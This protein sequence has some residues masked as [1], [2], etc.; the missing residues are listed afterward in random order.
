MKGKKLSHKERIAKIEDDKTVRRKIFKELCDHVSK[1]Y[2][3]ESFSG[4]SV[5]SIRKYLK[6]FSEEFVQEELDNAFRN[7]REMWETIGYRQANGQCLGNSRT[8]FY[9]MANRY[10]WRD[11]VEVEAEHKGQVSVN[12]VSYA[13]SKQARSNSDK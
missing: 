13:T 10:G 4:L 1:G 5:E 9:N 8:W 6:V 12:V 11:R 7:G 2:S 3:L